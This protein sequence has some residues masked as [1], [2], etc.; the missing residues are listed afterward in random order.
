MRST[1]TKIATI[2]GTVL[3]LGYCNPVH[4]QDISV[5]LESTEE[6]M[7]IA[8]QVLVEN[9]CTSVETHPKVVLT[10]VSSSKL[11]IEHA[12][13]EVLCMAW[14]DTGPNPVEDPTAEPSGP[15]SFSGMQTISLSWTPPSF[16]EDGTPLTLA[17]IKEYDIIYWWGDD[18]AMGYMGQ[19][20][21][22]NT[23]TSTNLKLPV[24]GGKYSFAIYVVDIGGNR[25]VAVSVS[26][27]I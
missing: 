15:D 14:E 8:T 3:A 9:G 13:T 26:I 23:R 20:E 25:S 11:T 2:V 19:L 21:L 17:E 5:S 18:P 12:I 22:N 6:A 10:Y 24:G 27:E 7:G 16:R 4:P 1:L